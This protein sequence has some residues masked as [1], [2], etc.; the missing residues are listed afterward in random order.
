MN[1]DNPGDHSAAQ[2]RAFKQPGAGAGVDSA[3]EQEKLEAQAPVSNARFV[4][5][6]LLRQTC[7][8]KIIPL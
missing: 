2:R 8:L 6:F 1:S 7:R 5:R 3:G 4:G